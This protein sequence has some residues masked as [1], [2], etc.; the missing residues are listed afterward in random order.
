MR[1][2]I[3]LLLFVFV[4]TSAVWA[5]SGRTRPREVEPKQPLPQI[6]EPP[7]DREKRETVADE[8]VLKIETSL[9]S[10][11][12]S[13]IDR[14]GHFLTNLRQQD[15]QIF[16][17]GKPQEIAHF[18][19]SEQPITIALLLDVS[20][21]TEYSIEEIR[22]AAATF[23]RQLKPVDRVMVVSF[24]E[25]VKVLSELTSDREKLYKAIGRAKIKDGTSLYD[26]VDYTLNRQLQQIQG[27]KAVVLFTDGVDTT[28]ELAT[29][30]SNIKDAQ[31]ADA[32]FYIIYYN[33]YDPNIDK[34]K[35]QGTGTSREEYAIAAEYLVDLAN[36][37]GGK[38]F[39]AG[40]TR[41]LENTFFSV[42]EELRWQYNL[43][44][45][46]TD[47]GQVGE[48]KN[49]KVRVN[50]DNVAVRARDNYIVGEQKATKK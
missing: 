3:I 20:Y 29:F 46:P 41:N 28:S 2:T 26:A 9:V 10:I 33:T 11:P 45:Y 15:F 31:E 6:A 34:G 39:S 24:A 1:K 22:N 19:A 12:V 32:A 47:P 4:W 48:R 37:T 18:A 5:Q 27:R 49:I 21:S 38:I 25:Q 23:I 44:Y 8:D 17:N 36:K 50:L 35:N 16:E 42:G 40:A 7:V 13:V 14:Q 30:A 43:G